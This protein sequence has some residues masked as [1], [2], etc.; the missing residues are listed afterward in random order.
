VTVGVGELVLVG[1]GMEVFVGVGVR[2]AVDVPV[3]TGSAVSVKGTIGIRSVAVVVL[4]GCTELH[5]PRKSTTSRELFTWKY[6]P[7][8]T[9]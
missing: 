3:G 1:V 5:A 9:F 2:V 7:I 4:T 8:K 6:L